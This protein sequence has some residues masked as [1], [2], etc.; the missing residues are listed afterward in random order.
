MGQETQCIRAGTL[1]ELKEVDFGG[2]LHSF[3]ICGELHDLELEV[4]K[5]Y[6]VEN[7]TYEMEKLQK[8]V[9]PESNE[10]QDAD[11]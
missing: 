4:L 2:P 10:T 7:S 8:D 5:E 11:N 6:L 3:I 9:V 1:K